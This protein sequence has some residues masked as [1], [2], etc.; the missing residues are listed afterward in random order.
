MMQHNNQ[1]VN[2][3]ADQYVTQGKSFF[4]NSN[5]FYAFDI[6]YFILLNFSFILDIL[7]IEKLFNFY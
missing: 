4:N 5:N 7:K 1:L 3:Y 2:S 6:N